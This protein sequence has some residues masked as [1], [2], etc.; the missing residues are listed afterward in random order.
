[1][2]TR[3]GLALGSTLAAAVAIWWLGASRIALLGG[4]DTAVLGTQALLVL[5]LL[6]AMLIAVLAPRAATAGGYA[7]GVRAAVPVVTAAW[8]VVALAAAAG[9]DGIG[10]AALVEAALLCG[11][12]TAPGV[13]RA[14]SMLFPGRAA[15]ESVATA[16]GIALA[17]AIWLLVMHGHA[18]TG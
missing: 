4:T 7:E 10:H 11:A 1:M 5:A 14:L 3:L 2:Y 9:I 8:P 6:R 15:H 13:G 18:V 12:L 17:G 16:L